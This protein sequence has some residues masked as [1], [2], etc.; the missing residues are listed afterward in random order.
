M[1][2]H[3]PKTKSQWQEKI[4]RKHRL[5]EL[6]PSDRDKFNQSS[7]YI[8]NNVHTINNLGF[9]QEKILSNTLKEIKFDFLIL[10]TNDISER[11]P[12]KFIIE[13]LKSRLEWNY[14]YE[15]HIYRNEVFIDLVEKYARMYFA[16]KIL[17]ANMDNL[18]LQ[19]KQ[20]YPEFHRID[21]QYHYESDSDSEEFSDEEEKD[22]KIYMYKLPKY[23]KVYLG[24]TSNSLKMIHNMHKTS[25]VSPLYKY[26]N[27]DE[28]F[29]DPTVIKTIKTKLN[30]KELNNDHELYKTIRAIKK[31]YNITD[32]QLLNKCR[33]YYN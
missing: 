13:G 18:K 24:F 19:M 9:E 29:E 23:D 14:D 33:Y 32:D 26:L 17:D 30:L 10:D 4:Q 15:N 28:K 31:E 21:C 27:L 25:H 8:S 20:I 11:L 12:F 3:Y 16:I 6:L 5:Q 7:E 22:V 2:H 1:N